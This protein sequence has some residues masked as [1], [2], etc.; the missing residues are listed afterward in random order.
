M[1]IIAP[2]FQVILIE[3]VRPLQH[4]AKH[5]VSSKPSRAIPAL[6]RSRSMVNGKHH[7]NRD[8]R[9]RK[10][11]KSSQ[12]GQ[13]RHPG[14]G[15][16]RAKPKLTSGL[17][18]GTGW[19]RT[20]GKHENLRPKAN[21]NLSFGENGFSKVTDLL[22]NIFYSQLRL[23]ENN[24]PFQVKQV[25]IIVLKQTVANNTMSE[26]FILLSSSSS[27]LPAFL[28]LEGSPP[29][30]IEEVRGKIQYQMFLEIFSKAVLS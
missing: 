19:G 3:L 18:L 4:L 1:K 29:E 7:A 22:L 28:F 10:G 16:T 5:P 8:D 23:C 27:S 6:L 26:P 30:K 15:G 21:R 17:S 2:A 25:F 14:E 12:A 9:A 24:N 20:A 13:G 11:P